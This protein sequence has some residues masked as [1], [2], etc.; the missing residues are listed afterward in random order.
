M[1]RDPQPKS[2]FFGTPEFAVPSLEAVARVTSVE[3]V[4]SQP[5]RP[6]G[7]GRRVSPTPVKAA[8]GRLGL[9]VAQ[10]QK[11]G[12][13]A[14]LERLEA[15][16]ADLVFVTAYGKIL[17]RRILEMPRLGCV[18]LH[19]SL[20]PRHRGAAPIQWAIMRGD[21]ATGLSLMLMDEGM[22]TGPVLA[23][24]STTIGDGETAGELS[25]RLAA[26]SGPFIERELPRYLAG[27]LEP[28][29]QGEGATLAPRL[30]PEDGIVDWCRPA[31]EIMRQ[32]R[33]VTPW[34]G[35]HTCAEGRQ[36]RVHEVRL[37]G[38]DDEEPPEGDPG[39]LFCGRGKMKV[40]CG[41]GW[42]EIRMIQPSGK[43]CME[44]DA[45]LRG[46]RLGPCVV[47]T[48]D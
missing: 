11:L 24:W 3:L 34:P 26:A 46:A 22:D 16:G 41:E 23:T 33:A 13:P 28:V 39:T 35:A 48:R 42:L 30:C 38:P 18:N 45:Y 20:L 10:P 21:A 31:A 4:V 15:A 32:V 5:D 9:E 12:D 17:P 2:V 19:A 14:F 37:P 25:E 29:D 40:R 36:M 47:L 6:A 43:R 1:D 7:R 44:A 8:A 27:Q